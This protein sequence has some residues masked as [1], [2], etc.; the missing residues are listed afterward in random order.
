MGGGLL[1]VPIPH[2]V[3]NHPRMVAK[4]IRKTKSQLEAPKVGDTETIPL[5]LLGSRKVIL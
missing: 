2:R 5:R 1:K 4:E 3:F